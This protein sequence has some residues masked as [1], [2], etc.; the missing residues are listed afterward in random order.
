[1]IR[2]ACHELE[3]FYL[4]DLAAVK[5]TYGIRLPSQQTRKYRTPD[6]LAN[7]ADELKRI[8]KQEYQK[9][10]GSRRIAEHMKL[11]GSNSSTS[12]NILISGIQ[13]LVANMM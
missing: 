2:I 5:Q 3:S 6:A 11:D 4:G 12:F 8:T 10:D 1:M 13:R 9:V 7:A